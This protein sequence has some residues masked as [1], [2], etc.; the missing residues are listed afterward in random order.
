MRQSLIKSSWL[1][2]ATLLCICAVMMNCSH[3][4]GRE[5]IPEKANILLIFTDDQKWNTIGRLGNH[6]IHTPNRL[7]SRP[8]YADEQKGI[9]KV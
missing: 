2:A 8:Q 3:R 6:E 4:N 9:F 5:K 1:V 7:Y